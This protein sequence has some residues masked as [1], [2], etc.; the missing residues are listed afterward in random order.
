MDGDL[1]RLKAV[2]FEQ[3]ERAILKRKLAQSELD[4][5]SAKLEIAEIRERIW[6]LIQ[7]HEP[8]AEFK[9]FRE[10]AEQLLVFVLTGKEENNGKED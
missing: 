3:V 8:L 9:E 7:A 6:R 10:K 5:A 4:K 1:N 2:S